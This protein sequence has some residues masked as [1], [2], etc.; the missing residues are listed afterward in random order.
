M[1]DAARATCP[2]CGAT[3]SADD[4]ACLCPRC[5]LSDTQGG[6]GDDSPVSPSPSGRVSRRR[7][8]TLALAVAASTAIVLVGLWLLLWALAVMHYNLAVDLNHQGKLEEA[9]AEYRTAIRLK[10]DL[11]EAQYG[12]GQSS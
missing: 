10:P 6:Q 8:L 11:V 7:G 12:L 9:I 2:R 3:I 4:P 1:V 5:R